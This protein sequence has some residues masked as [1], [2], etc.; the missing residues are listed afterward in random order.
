MGVSSHVC[1]RTASRERIREQMMGLCRHL[2]IQSRLND[3][4]RQSQFCKFLLVLSGLS[5]CVA[6]FRNERLGYG[7]YWHFAQQQRPSCDV[8]S[9]DRFPGVIVLA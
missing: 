4:Q 3:K 7:W 2:N 1:E 5:F 6:N 9:V 8:V